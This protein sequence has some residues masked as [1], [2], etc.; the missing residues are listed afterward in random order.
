MFGWFVGGFDYWCLLLRFSLFY[1]LFAF[2]LWWLIV[3]V[4]LP[5]GWIKLLS[6]FLLD[7]LRFTVLR[8][9]YWVC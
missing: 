1:G 7:C 8:L 3:R 6:G 5:L 4:S 9:T 2:M